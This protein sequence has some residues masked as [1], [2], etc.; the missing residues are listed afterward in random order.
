MHAGQ[1]ARGIDRELF[2]QLM[3]I[4]GLGEVIHHATHFFTGFK[5]IF[6]SERFVLMPALG[7]KIAAK[8]CPGRIFKKVTT[9]PTMG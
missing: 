7:E 3:N 9:L 1:K 4:P 5:D 8:E 6:C 2:H